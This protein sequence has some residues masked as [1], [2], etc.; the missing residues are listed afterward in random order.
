MRQTNV[1]IVIPSLVGGG[2]ERVAIDLANH[3]S[4]QSRD[5]TLITIDRSDI[6]RY[7]VQETVRRVGLGLMSQS[8]SVL[9]AV[10]NNLQRVAKLRNAIGETKATAVVSFTDITNITTLLACRQLTLKTIVC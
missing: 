3:W 5:V 4:L 9:S 8:Q 6:S 7:F 1:A 10:R 2:A